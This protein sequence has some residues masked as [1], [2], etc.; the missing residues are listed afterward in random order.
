MDFGCGKGGDLKKF[1]FENISNYVGVDISL[2]QLKDAVMRK[3]SSQIRYPALFIKASGEMDSEAFFKKIPEETY[4][5]LVSAQFCIHYFFESEASVRRFLE[6]ISRKL[7]KNGRFVATFPDSNVIMKKLLSNYKNEEMAVAEN[8]YVSLMMEKEDLHKETPFGIKY[9][10][11]LDDKLIGEKR[12]EGDTTHIIY[13]PEYLVVLQSFISLA[14]EYGLET[15]IN[16]NFHEF[17]AQNIQDNSYFDLFKRMNFGIKGDRL[18]DAEEWD[19][20]YLYR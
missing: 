3:T 8:K 14:K 12:I 5:D 15:E 9:G 16:E 7:T 17:Y 4:F 10:F 2:G 19:C 13:V 18:M 20:S 1:D 11:F 6:N